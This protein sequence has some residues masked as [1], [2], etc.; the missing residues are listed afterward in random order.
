MLEINV[1][2]NNERA[3]GPYPVALICVE[4]L[5]LREMMQGGQQLLVKYTRSV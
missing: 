5:Y 1:F 4:A 3:P 2:W